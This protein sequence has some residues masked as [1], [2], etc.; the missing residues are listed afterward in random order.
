M[1]RLTRLGLVALGLIL[2]FAGWAL[3]S[4]QDEYG[5][6]LNFLAESDANGRTVVY[7]VD[8]QTSSRTPVFEGSVQEAQ[9]SVEGRQRRGNHP[10]RGGPGQWCFAPLLGVPVISA[11]C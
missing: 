3:W 9:E 11:S 7:E 1:S 8:E 6:G 4:F 10:S 5:S 2:L